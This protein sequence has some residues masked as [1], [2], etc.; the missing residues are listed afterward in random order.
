[1][2]NYDRGVDRRTFLVVVVLIVGMISA[3]FA[4]LVLLQNKVSERESV[5]DARQRINNA[6]YE[7][8]REAVCVVLNGLP[9]APKH[10]TEPPSEIA[11]LHRAYVL[12][13]CKPLPHMSSS[14]AA[15]TSHSSPSTAG[16]A[17]TRP[18]LPAATTTVTRPGSAGTV[19]TP[20]ARAPKVAPAV[21]PAAVAPAVTPNPLAS[22]LDGVTS[23][24]P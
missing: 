1:M 12:S 20:R 13:G 3:G 9:P 23:L 2:P 16:S 14:A 17:V 21:T 15:S 4:V 5:G 22:L 10:S 24:L 8:N 19:A 6:R 7:R 11:A 18:P